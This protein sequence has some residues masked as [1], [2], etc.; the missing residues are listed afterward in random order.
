MNTRKYKMLCDGQFVGFIFITDNNPIVPEGKL[1]TIWPFEKYGNWTTDDIEVI[2]HQYIMDVF[3][4]AKTDEQ[5]QEDLISRSSVFDNCGTFIID[6][7][8]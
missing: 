1:A 8:E 5:I 6:Q 4:S 2:G 7:Y 3:P